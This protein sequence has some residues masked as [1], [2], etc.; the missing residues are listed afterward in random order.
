MFRLVVL[1]MLLGGCTRSEQVTPQY[2]S[3]EQDPVYQTIKGLVQDQSNCFKREAQSK[4]LR[5]VDLD[6]AALAVMGKC[7]AERQR[8]K[9]FAARNTIEH[10]PQFEIRWRAEEADDL[11]FIKQ[12]LAIIRTQ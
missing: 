9:A 8:Y 5:A 12:M 4:S 11:L 6:T 7:A 1:L 2:Q 10:P 3:R